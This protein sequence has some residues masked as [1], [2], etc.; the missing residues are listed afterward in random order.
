M[1]VYKDIKKYNA[2]R[3]DCPHRYKDC[4]SVEPMSDCAKCFENGKYDTKNG[5]SYEEIM[6]K[7]T[8]NFNELVEMSKNI[9][10]DA[11]KSMSR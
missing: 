7:E 4:G 5:H 11:K 9:I 1:I 3:L 2:F 6:K 10:A 8:A